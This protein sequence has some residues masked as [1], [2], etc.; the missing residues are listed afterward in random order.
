MRIRQPGHWPRTVAE[1][2]AVQE[3]LAW[4]AGKAEPWR[5]PAERPVAIG[6]AFIAYRTGISGVGERGDPAWAAA[7]AMEGGVRIAIATAEGTVGASYIAGSL[8]LREGPLLEQVVR[9]L[10][11]QPEV[12]LVDATGLDHPRRAGLALHL[13]AVLDLPTVG[14]TDR[15]LIAT[16]EEP[17]R[18]RGERAPLMIGDELVGYALR[19]RDGVRRLFIHAAWRTDPNT[20]CD[21]VLAV[22]EKTRTPEPLREARRLARE[23]RSRELI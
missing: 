2:E 14:V 11:P 19:T 8:A 1:L 17:G 5:F 12:L 7:T 10:I 13:G 9:Q 3:E 4:Q 15:T 23:A 6:G 16:A 21:V 18:L 20:A 22:M